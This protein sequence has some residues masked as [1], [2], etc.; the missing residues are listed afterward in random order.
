MILRV[1]AFAVAATNVPALAF[2]PLSCEGRVDDAFWGLELLGNAAVWH[3][4]QER[5]T[6]PITSTLP[7]PGPERRK[8]F[9]IADENSLHLA[10]A[11]ETGCIRNELSFPVRLNV[12]SPDDPD[13]P[14]RSACCTG[15]E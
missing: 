3:T 6:L 10:V 7:L 15:A 5:Q 13:H 4:A 8:L 11:T 9:V 2:P 12:L 14:V 1:A